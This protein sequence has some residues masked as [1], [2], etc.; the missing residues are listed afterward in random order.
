[1]SD[2]WLLVVSLMLPPLALA[3]MVWL[4]RFEAESEASL[5]PRFATA[6]VSGRASRRRLAA[7]RGPTLRS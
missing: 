1:M 3:G 5:R 6:D 2:L 7:G 4:A